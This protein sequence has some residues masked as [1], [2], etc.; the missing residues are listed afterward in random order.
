[1]LSLW[2]TLAGVR[3]GQPSH[4]GPPD[5]A[6]FA[7]LRGRIIMASETAATAQV[8][9]IMSPKCRLI[10]YRPFWGPPVPERI[11]PLTGKLGLRGAAVGTALF[12]RVPGRPAVDPFV[13]EVASSCRISECF[14]TCAGLE[15]KFITVYGGPQ[16]AIDASA[17]NNWLLAQAYCRIQTSKIP[18]IVG[19]DFNSDPTAHPVWAS[20]CQAGYVELGQFA[21]EALATELP[22][23][24][25]SSTRFD[26]MLVPSSLLPYVE[27]A[28]VMS[29]SHIFDS[30]S[31]MRLQLR[32]PGSRPLKYQWQLP[33]SWAPLAVPA[34][35][36]AARYL[37]FSKP[38]RSAF[39]VDMDDMSNKLQV[40]SLVN[41]AAVS[42]ALAGECRVNPQCRT[43][44]MRQLPARFRGRCKP[45]HRTPQVEPKLPRHAR[46]GEPQPQTE[47]TQV[48]CRQ[49]LRQARRLLTY[50]RGLA[51][52][53]QKVEADPRT[54]GHRRWTWNGQPSLAVQGTKVPLWIGLCSGLVSSC[55]PANVPGWILC[56]ICTSWFC[57]ITRPC[58]GSSVLPSA[59]LSDIG[60]R[61]MLKLA[62]R[63]WP[64]PVSSRGHTLPCTTCGAAF[65]LGWRRLADSPFGAGSTALAPRTSSRFT[66]RCSWHDR[67]SGLA[68]LFHH[69]L[70]VWS[71]GRRCVALAGRVDAGWIGLVHFGN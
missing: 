24:C 27:R 33:C 25:K 45:R 8:Q 51:S 71:T 6:S 59:P 1:M 30:H 15:I 36:V 13:D 64:F 20:F 14:V 53:F 60:F 63:L 39:K 10:G 58:P 52:Y 35:L 19:G 65:R 40:W 46:D 43:P 7:S 57:L 69:Y 41:E 62:A 23:T 49:R 11:H 32:V 48:V 42:R 18:A 44:P 2:V 47:V 34:D 37:E 5:S 4:P 54:L 28:D 17:K 3:V 67:V 31:P 16:C 29:Q 61:W 21:R 55:G 12:T 9:K 56:G 68:F 66:R 26:T 70:S 22:P 50:H 38:V